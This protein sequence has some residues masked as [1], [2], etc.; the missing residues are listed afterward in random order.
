M[1]YSYDLETQNRDA[2][3]VTSVGYFS[4]YINPA[5]TRLDL[6]LFEAGRP[7]HVTS[8]SAA[9]IANPKLSEAWR[10]AT[11]V[12]IGHGRDRS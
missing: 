8:E 5:V 11:T 6:S 7:V 4:H 2:L 10:R 1:I 3:E 9:A 12:T